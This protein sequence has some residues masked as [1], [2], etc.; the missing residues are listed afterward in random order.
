MRYCVRLM[1]HRL[2]RGDAYGIGE[3]VGRLL[4]FTATRLRAATLLARTV[5]RVT[6]VPFVPRIHLVSNLPGASALGDHLRAAGLGP[7]SAR[8][9]DALLVGRGAAR[10]ALPAGSGMSR[11]RTV[12]SV[13]LG[14]IIVVTTLLPL[15]FVAI[16]TVT[17]GWL[18]ITDNFLPLENAVLEQNALVINTGR[19][20]ARAAVIAASSGACPCRRA[21][22]AN[23]TSRMALAMAT[24]IAMIVPMKD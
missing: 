23:V 13:A 17:A 1:V 16:T 10:T 7:T 14:G 3:R 2:L 5:G 4:P 24:P 20:R 15:A 11:G 21:C 12:V 6:R 9:A 22:S 18:S 19:I 8:S